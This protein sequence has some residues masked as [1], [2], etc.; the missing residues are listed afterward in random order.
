MPNP[1]VSRASSIA[2]A[3]LRLATGL[4]LAALVAACGTPRPQDAGAPPRSGWPGAP[5]PP[6]LP[7]P[8]AMTQ[9]EQLEDAMTET[10]RGTP[11]AVQWADG[12]TV[13]IVVP[14]QFSFDAGR[15]AVK[16]PLAAVLDRL[17]T[18]LRSKPALSVEVTGPA[19]ARAGAVLSQDRAEAT[20]DYLIGRGVTVNRF[21]A[22]VR[23]GTAGEVEVRVADR[24]GLARTESLR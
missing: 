4:C 12:S 9:L 24:T 1:F 13:R 18:Q 8:S 23:V 17:A 21:S 16:R 3:G 15:S 10:L 11:V 19:D 20:R 22:P 7:P 6:G 5:T 14:L 2:R